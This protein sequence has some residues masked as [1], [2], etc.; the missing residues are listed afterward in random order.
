MKSTKTIKTNK[1]T[2]EELIKLI[3][4]AVQFKFSADPTEPGLLVSRLKKGDKG[5][6]YVSVLRFEKAF[7]QGKKVAYKARAATLLTALRDIAKQIA[8]DGSD[9]PLQALRNRSAN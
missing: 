1:L 7:G 4:S 6:V 3:T 8:N 2:V 5:K 9:N